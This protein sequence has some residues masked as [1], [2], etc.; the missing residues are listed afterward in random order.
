[1]LD[2]FLA[3]VQQSG[4]CLIWTGSTH[5]AGYGQFYVRGR[6]RVFAHR[7]AYEMTK[8][9]IPKGLCVCHSCDTPA[10]VNPQ[11]LWLGTHQDNIQDKVRKNRQAR[12]AAVARPGSLR[13]A[14]KLSEKDISAILTDTRSVRTIAKQY[15]VHHCQI[16]R[17]KNK[18]A[19]AHCG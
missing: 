9:E 19:W 7:Y 8:G 18:T 14:A 11:H 3:N 16:V 10:C 2:K 4:E 12:G 15:G 6:G 13:P 1:M 5:P 17:I